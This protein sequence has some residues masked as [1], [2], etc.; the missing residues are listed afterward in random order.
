M[1]ILQLFHIVWY[2]CVVI[3]IL[4]VYSTYL[5]YTFD[6]SEEPSIWLSIAAA[7]LKHV[8]GLAISGIMLG[9]VLNYGWLVPDLL[10]YSGYR[11]MGRISYATFMCHL[12]V[13]KLLM[14]SVHQPIYLSDLNIVSKTYFSVES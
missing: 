5:F 11:I 7:A 4:N 6:F 12:F 10:N 14:A 2:L 1:N 3:A 9:L 13:V 8:W